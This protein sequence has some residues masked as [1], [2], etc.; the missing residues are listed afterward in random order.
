[1]SKMFC[2][3]LVRREKDKNKNKDKI[4]IKIGNKNKGKD[5]SGRT[6]WSRQQWW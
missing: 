2:F 6:G 3:Y 5:V 4:K 1:M